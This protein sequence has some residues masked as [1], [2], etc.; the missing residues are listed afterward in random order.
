MAR[1]LSNNNPGNIVKSGGTPWLGE[2]R[3]SKDVRFAQ[4]SSM[5]YGYRALFKLLQN[6]SK[7]HG[8]S[9]VRKMI[10]R[11]APPFENNTEAY[12]RFVCKHA[13][14]DADA[15]IDITDKGVMMRLAAAITEMEN[16]EKADEKAMRKGWEL[17]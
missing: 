2:I 4:F 6:Y 15:T 10:T 17:L 14:V 7:L 11:W 9:T 13:G 12:I 5:E 1:G 8:C 16:G 3:P